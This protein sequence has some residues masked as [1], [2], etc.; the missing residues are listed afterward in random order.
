M[1]HNILS[2]Y[3]ILRIDTHTL[4]GGA[5]QSVR[6]TS[7]W[8]TITVSLANDHQAAPDCPVRHQTIRCAK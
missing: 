2:A 6:A 8:P 5:A 7:A 4:G 3:L 1:V